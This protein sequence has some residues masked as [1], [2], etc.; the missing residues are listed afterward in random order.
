MRFD[1]E[2]K[3]DLDKFKKI[4]KYRLKSGSDGKFDIHLKEY[5]ISLYFFD[6]AMGSEYCHVGIKLFDLIN[7]NELENMI[8]IEPEFDDRFNKIKD[9]MDIFV[10][11]QNETK[12]TDLDSNLNTVCKLITIL[13]KFNNLKI[14]I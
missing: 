13:H 9:F 10:N 4:I 12:F 7:K 14:F 8:L 6:F 5:K 2:N 3:L 11:G 1:F